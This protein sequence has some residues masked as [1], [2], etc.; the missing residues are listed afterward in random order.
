MLPFSFN[1]APTFSEIKGV[2]W[3][4]NT[5]T[6]DIVTCPRASQLEKVTFLEQQMY[7]SDNTDNWFRHP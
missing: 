3:T 4:F 1:L 5:L 6:S 2:F 7:D